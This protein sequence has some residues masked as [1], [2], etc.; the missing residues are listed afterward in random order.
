M[1]RGI[2]KTLPVAD[3]MKAVILQR[4]KSDFA[5]VNSQ[6]APKSPKP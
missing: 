5:A 4:I 1:S 2:A 6:S 3:E